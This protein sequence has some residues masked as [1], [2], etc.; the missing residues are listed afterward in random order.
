MHFNITIIIII[1]LLLCLLDD[2][3]EQ[4]RGLGKNPERRK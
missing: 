2:D 1:L 4:E 3:M